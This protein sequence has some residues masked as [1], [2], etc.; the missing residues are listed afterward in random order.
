VLV[1]W[2]VAATP[3]SA[4]NPGPSGKIA[5]TKS[6]DIW[7]V[8]PDGSGLTQLTNTV[9]VSEADPTFSP[10]GNYIAYTRNSNAYLF[11]MRADGSE[12]HFLANIFKGTNL[13]WSP[14]GSKIAYLEP[15]FAGGTNEIW[16]INRD[17]SGR[18]RLIA[19]DDI[20]SGPTWS[21]DGA[22][23]AFSRITPPTNSEEIW[24]MN[25]DGSGATPIT[26]GG[27]S[28]SSCKRWPNWSPDGSK[29]V[30]ASGAYCG[31]FGGDTEIYTVPSA[32]GAVTQVG[33]RPGTI[34]AD[35]NWSPD[36]TRI[37]FT[38]CV[39]DFDLGECGLADIYVMNSGGSATLLEGTAANEVAP[40]WQPAVGPPLPPV[41][42][43]LDKIAFMSTRNGVDDI[44]TMNPDGSGLRA[45]TGGGAFERDPAWSPDGSKIAFESNRA[46]NNSEIYTMNPDGT[47]VTNL[48]QTVDPGINERGPTWSP[49]G[50]QIA[51]ERDVGSAPFRQIWTM[52]SGGTG[53]TQITPGPSDTSPA[54]SPDGTKIAFSSG[55]IYTMSPNGSNLTQLTAPQS[56][57]SD[58]VPA[59][60][61][62]GSQI[63]FVRLD[64]TVSPSVRNIWVMNADGS[65]QHQLVSVP[66]GSW[67][68]SWS[69]DGTKIAFSRYVAYPG[70][71]TGI[72]V[73]NSD[74]TGQVDVSSSWASSNDQPD[75]KKVLGYPRPKGATPVRLP[76]VPAEA[77]CTSPNNAHGAPL[78]SGSCSPPSLTSQ[79]LTT[80]TPD[81]NG[82]VVLMNSYLQL[83]AVPGNPATPADEADLGIQAHVNDVFNRDMT[84]YAGEL[85]TNLV[86]RITDKDNNPAT[87]GSA[88]GTLRLFEFTVDAPCVADPDPD[89]GS[90]CSVS[91]TAD[92]LV[93]GAIKESKR[94]IWQLSR[95]RVFDGGADGDA[96]TTADNTLFLTQGVFVP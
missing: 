93:P 47:G 87:N 67:A 26:A 58:D 41:P 72:F 57:V 49:D 53:Q 22:K 95:V 38:S 81:A 17:G 31:N 40:D 55:G 59:W 88:A 51:Y 15:A 2:F 23:I 4:T 43:Y 75:W 68:P 50:A 29:I 73:M 18:T 27:T 63:A 12:P 21:P 10:D 32:G 39:Y 33:N 16:V 77:Q 19:G 62:D 8:N 70:S 7:S 94:T 92:T 3:A 90:D 78:S 84:D 85:R 25:A 42:S 64:G 74:G 80:G 83:T 1:T 46:G 56:G 52:S 60:S 61:P 65:A 13:A 45:L 28:P 54:W 82:R 30:F 86:P 5:F 20:R 14:D 6:G 44:F 79:Y 69:P 76:L 35:P 34:E 36:G 71:D 89:I 11:I 37:A 48:T 24:T 66:G 9:G 91:T 96:A